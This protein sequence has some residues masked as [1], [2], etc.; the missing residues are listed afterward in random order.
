MLR[1]VSTP[2]FNENGVTKEVFA[3]VLQKAENDSSHEVDVYLYY[4]LVLLRD[5][6]S[7]LEFVLEYY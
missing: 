7:L 5:D 1:P 2:G 3:Y 4:H 6:K